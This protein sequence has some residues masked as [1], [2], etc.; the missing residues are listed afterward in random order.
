MMTIV[1]AIFD[2]PAKNHGSWNCLF[3][4]EATFRKAI[5]I[6]R[7]NYD[8]PEGEDKFGRVDKIHVYETPAEFV[9]DYE[10]RLREK[11]MSKLSDAEIRL[12]GLAK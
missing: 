9:Q 11:A 4:D 5:Q 3:K 2:D 10:R 6:I 1:E 7:D 8:I 12:L